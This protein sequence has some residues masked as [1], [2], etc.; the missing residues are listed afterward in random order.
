M[1]V[2]RRHVFLF[3][4]FAAVLLALFG[5]VGRFRAENAAKTVALVTDYKD[6]ISI[7]LQSGRNKDDVW[8][9]LNSNGISGVT[10]SEYTGEELTLLSP[11]SF[12][13]GSASVL[14]CAKDGI[15]P[16]RA[17]LSFPAYLS[18]AD[19]LS[20]YIQKKMPLTAVKKEKNRVF[21]LLP[22]TV[23][24][25]R[26]CAFV[27]DFDALDFCKK[28]EIPVLF[29]PGP[30][31][32]ASGETVAASFEFLVS[33]YPVVKNIVPAGLIMA[34]YPDIMPL[35]GVMKRKEVTLSSVEFVKQVGVSNLAVAVSPLIVQMHSL[36][37][38]EIISKKISQLQIV[39]RYV[40]AVH[41]RSIRVILL[42]PYDLQMGDRPAIFLSD[43]KI[44][45]EA[46]EARGYKMGWAKPI[47]VWPVSFAGALAC[48]LSLVFSGWFFLSRLK[49]KENGDTKSSAIIVL[50]VFTLILSVL[51][52]KVHIAAKILGGICGAFIAAEGALSALESSKRPWF[53]ALAGL[54]IVMAG[55]L[56]I[57]S[58]YGNVQGALRLT[59][60]SGVK[61]TLLLPPVLLL[62]H[63]FKRRIHPESLSEIAARPAL[64]VE[65]F[66]MGLLLVALV[67]MAL[68]SDNVSNVPAYE[69]AFRDFMERLL[70]VRPRTKEFLIG[71]PALVLYWYFVRN[72]FAA[73]YRE[74]LR[75][76]A[77]LAFCSAVNTFC[78]FHTL[79]YLGVLRTLNGWWLGL[80]IGALI[81]AFIHYAALPAIRKRAF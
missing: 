61:L 38:D 67:V 75:I 30:C 59:P 58:F 50:F 53:G 45:K 80:L 49:G 71:Y 12:R 17:V 55:G 77:V 7:S 68:R 23:D 16:D 36:T 62:I 39:E 37:K 9:E 28:N 73:K 1:N 57:A 18:C 31:T 52:F 15:L 51:L 8:R 34:G 54:L 76:T 63:D 32:P 43:S 13:Y 19:S 56:A 44:I 48:S 41:E 33:L 3:A 40:R 79:I 22:G 78:H 35:A 47:S 69:I 14:G 24:E 66:L 11:M 2:K 26:S 6:I 20:R 72:G 65:L 70:I 21:L 4:V 29:R 5:S 42:H 64:W 10:A 27:P 60:F 74:L 46:L 81:V 25:F